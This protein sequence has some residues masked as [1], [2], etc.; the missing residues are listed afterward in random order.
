[1]FYLPFRVA[2]LIVLHAAWVMGVISYCVRD[3]TPRQLPTDLMVGAGAAAG[4]P[5]SQAGAPNTNSRPGS[6]AQVA[7]YAV[8][9]LEIGSDGGNDCIDT[10]LGAVVV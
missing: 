4:H 8:G 2:I 6:T 3:T 10:L 9:N 5:V 7:A 1:M